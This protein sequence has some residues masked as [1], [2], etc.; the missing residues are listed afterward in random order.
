MH[1]EWVDQLTDDYPTLMEAIESA[2][3]AHSKG[4][5]YICFMSVRLL[6]MHRILKDTGSIYLHCDPTASHYLKAIMD[7]MSGQKNFRNEIIWRRTGAHNMAY[8]FG[9]VHD[10]LLFYS[11]SDKYKHK[12]L[13]TPYLKGHVASFFNKEDSRGRYWTNS[14]HG[15][16][17]RGGESGKPW[18]N[19]DPAAVGRHWAVPKEFGMMHLAQ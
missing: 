5:A 6:E 12:T 16:G 11:R 14:I 17:I 8:K 2:M 4:M 15:D 19:Y 13:F 7:A 1:Q 18:K 10:V 3:H 9:P